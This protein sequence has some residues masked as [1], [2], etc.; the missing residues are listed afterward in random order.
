MLE[1]YRITFYKSIHT[2]RIKSS[3]IR[4]RKD[5]VQKNYNV[6]IKMLGDDSFIYEMRHSLS[7]HVK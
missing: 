6:H 7:V 4:R 1:K 2:Y 5:K 3:D